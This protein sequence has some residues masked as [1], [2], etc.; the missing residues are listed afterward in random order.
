MSPIADSILSGLKNVEDDLTKVSTGI[1]AL[2]AG[3]PQ[4]DVV[5]KSTVLSDSEYAKY[6]VAVQTQVTRDFAPHWKVDARITFTTIPDPTHWQVI[7]LDTSDQ[8]GA[9]G[10]HDLTAAGLPIGYVFAKTDLENSASVSVTLSHELLEMLGDPWINLAVQVSPTQFVAFENADCVEADGDGY[11][12]GDVLVSDFVL[13]SYFEMSGL[14][15]F[16]FKNWLSGRMPTIR[17]EGY[18]SVWDAK[19]GGWTQVN[20]SRVITPGAKFRARPKNGSRRARRM[21]PREQW[22]KSTI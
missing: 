3:D 17:P 11:L 1:G 4:I 10:Y 20:G 13:P 5:N 2:S 21:I 12:I 19:A 15:P 8:A 7:I 18:L 22:L 6:V 14:G 9:L 16:D